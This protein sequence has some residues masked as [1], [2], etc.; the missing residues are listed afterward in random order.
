M[1]TILILISLIVGIYIGWKYEHVV[2]DI[3]E[4]IKTHLN[5]K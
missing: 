5:I 1:T 2:N 3:I 4:S